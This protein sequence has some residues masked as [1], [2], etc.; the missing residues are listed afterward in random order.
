MK[1]SDPDGDSLTFGV[2]GVEGRDL[3]RI[4]QNGANEANVFLRKA[5]DREVSDEGW[6]EGEDEKWV[7]IKMVGMT[8]GSKGI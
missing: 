1:G 5:L 4:E 3:L 8:E 7:E 6:K 2:R